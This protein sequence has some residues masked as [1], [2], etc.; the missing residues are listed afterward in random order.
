[1]RMHALIAAI[2]SLLRLKIGEVWSSRPNPE[3]T[4]V[5]IE[6][7]ATSGQKTGKNRHI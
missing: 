2:M 6:S 7:F 4:S 5:E 1:M 3:L